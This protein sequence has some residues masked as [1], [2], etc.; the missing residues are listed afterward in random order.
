MD[1]LNK[2]ALGVSLVAIIFATLAVFRAPQSIVRTVEKLGAFPGPELLD[3]FVFRQAVTD[4]GSIAT[5]SELSSLTMNA[6][7][8]NNVSS[9]SFAPGVASFTLTLPA[10]STLTNFVPRAGDVRYVV[11]QNAT[12][13]DG[14]NLTLVGNTGTILRGVH[15]TSTV[16]YDGMSGLMVFR[17]SATTTNIYAE[18]IPQ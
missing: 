16:L 3:H 1:K 14:I 17:R 7:E 15:G 10:S 18:F 13:T 2:F 6:R 12:G 8:L 4:G 11:F 9:Y 5:S